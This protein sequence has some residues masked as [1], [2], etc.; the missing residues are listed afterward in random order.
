MAL[1]GINLGLLDWENIRAIC[2]VFA[3]QQPGCPVCWIQRRESQVSVWSELK[4]HHC[5]C[6]WVTY[7][8]PNLFLTPNS[9]SWHLTHGIKSMCR[10]KRYCT[11][12][13]SRN[14]ND[15][16]VTWTISNWISCGIDFLETQNFVDLAFVLQ[17]D[18]STSFFCPSQPLQASIFCIYLSLC[19]DI[20]I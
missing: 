7:F 19:R 10:A 1:N 16:E 11:D 4:L 13:F 17:A 8:F 18:P 14:W 15:P 5:L 6:R 20:N 9:R 12:L 3:A 2:F